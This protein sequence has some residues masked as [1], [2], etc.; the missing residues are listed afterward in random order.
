MLD[1]HLKK[2]F[3]IIEKLLVHN[4]SD[5][6]ICTGGIIMESIL[7]GVPANIYHSLIKHNPDPIFILDR[8]GFVIE[9]NRA[10]ESIFGYR[11]EDVIGK[12]C[13]LANGQ[14]YDFSGFSFYEITTH[15]KNGQTLHLQV[16]TLPMFEDNVLVNILF[17]VKDLTSLVQNRIDLQKMSENLR[18]IYETSADAMD[19]IDL[20]GNVI[21]VNKAFEEMYGW[22]AEEIIGKPMP[23]IPEERLQQVHKERQQV[24]NNGSIKNLE[25]NCLKKDGTLIPVNISI[26]PLR[27]EHGK[28]IAFSAISR[29]ISERKEWERALNKSKNKYKSLLNAL[30]EPSYV[31]SGGII[32]YINQAAVKL[33]GYSHPSEVLGRHVLELSHPESHSIIKRMIRQLANEENIPAQTIELKMVRADHSVFTAEITFIG[34]EFEDNLSVHVLFKDITEKKRIEEALIRSEEKYRLI[35]ENMTDLLT[36]VDDQRNI[37]YASPSTSSILGYMPE[38]YEGNRAFGKAHPDDLP[39]IERKMNELFQTKG[40]NEMEFRYRHKTLEWIWL[41]AKGT[42]FIDEENGKGFLLYVSRVIEEKK[43]MREK[44]KQMAFHDELT[45]LPNRRL[46][47]EKLKQVLLDS[48]TNH[49]KFALLYL[50]IDKFKWVND[51]LGHATGDE[52]LK[53]FAVRVS[54]ILSDQAVLAR[55]GGDEFLLLLPDIIDED[56]VKA[57]ADRIVKNL[58]SEWNIAGHHFTTTSSVGAAMYPQDGTTIDELLTFADRALYKAKKNGRNSYMLYSDSLE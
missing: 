11:P 2:H 46:F 7:N 26:S 5:G 9:I 10:V 3:I 4:N 47:Q 24:A 40:T 13:E 50:D 6:K 39:M 37:K 45:G 15:N 33:L 48:K 20:N 1:I 27:D 51:H 21:Q 17:I 25:V 44:L 18:S 19:I 29:D 16:K 8:N 57:T 38:H 53:Q 43:R 49:L 12:R 14:I 31:Q 35:A 54:G 32:K 22:K 58:Q 23:T 42:Y 55:Q 28:V 41:E 52:L 30:P 34:I 56:D 36:I